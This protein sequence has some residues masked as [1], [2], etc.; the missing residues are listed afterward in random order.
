MQKDSTPN[1]VKSESSFGYHDGEV[2]TVISVDE[3]MTFED[4]S[5]SENK[6][7]VL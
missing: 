3:A 6:E 1:N 4:E 2:E 5:S 7:M